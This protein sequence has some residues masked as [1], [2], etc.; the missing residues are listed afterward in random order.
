[1]YEVITSVPDPHCCVC[2]LQVMSRGEK[3]VSKTAEASA[4][5]KVIQ[6]PE[7]KKEK[8]VPLHVPVLS[9][10]PEPIQMPPSFKEPIF[11]KVRQA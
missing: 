5:I 9:S 4:N 6:K 8:P 2:V 11:G 1:M 7:L 3:A 10:K